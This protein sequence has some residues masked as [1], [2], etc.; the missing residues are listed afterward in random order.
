MADALKSKL[1][2]I[3]LMGNDGNQIVIGTDD[4]AEV[5]RQSW[6]RRM[7]GEDTLASRR[8]SEADD[9]AAEQARIAEA[10]EKRREEQDL[11]QTIREEEWRQAQIQQRMAAEQ[12][13]REAQAKE[14]LERAGQPTRPA[15]SALPSS[16]MDIPIE[17]M[18][19][20]IWGALTEQQQNQYRQKWASQ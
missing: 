16:F 17:Q 3:M 4:L 10:L 2:Y 13:R 8:Q 19:D 11:R 5:S 6:F 18:N 7:T 12:A 15:Q 1:H 20:N 14:E 9:Y